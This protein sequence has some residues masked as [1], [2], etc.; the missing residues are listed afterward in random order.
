MR[1]NLFFGIIEPLDIVIFGILYLVTF[2]GALYLILKNEKSL[3]L[4]FWILTIL[5]IPLFGSVFYL[6]KHLLNKSPI[7]D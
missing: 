2:L 3:F 5:F 1:Q 6:M 4:F 7:I